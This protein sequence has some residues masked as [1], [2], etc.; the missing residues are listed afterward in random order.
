V[1]WLIREFLVG[2][3]IFY[4][5]VLVQLAPA[6]DSALEQLYEAA[7]RSLT[8]G[9]YPEAQRAFEQ[10][11]QAHPEIAEIRANLGL[12][13]FEE[14]QFDK[15]VPELRRALKLKPALT[16][17][18]ALLAMSLSELGQYEEALAG[19]EKGFRSPDPQMKRMCGLQ[20]ER[21]Y[22]GM[23]RDNKAVEIAL[24]MSHFYPDDPEVLYHNGR[25]FGNFAF[26]S[27]QRLSQL[28]PESVWTHQAAAEAYESQGS[29]GSAIS[30]YRQVLAMEPRRP[31]VHYRLGRTLLAQARATT[32]AEDLTSAVSEFDEEL[33]LDPLNA[34][35]AY[36]IGEI[37][38]RAAEF[39]DAQEHF[40]LALKIYPDLE[41]AHLGLAAVL[42]Y[43]RKPQLALPHLQKAASLNSENEVTWYRLSQVERALGNPEE[44]Q[45]AL[46]KFHELHQ[47]KT[48]QE[49]ASKPLFSAEE[50]TKQTLD[51][52]EAQ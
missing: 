50:V 43:L 27:I 47:R 39:E 35:A 42:T 19:L 24:E 38:R 48:V 11:A 22:T 15:A 32:S 8:A 3:T 26:L 18:A 28:A 52:N 2:L 37:H 33:K 25:I 1:N 21:A 6:Q 51:P 34:S 29:Y 4:M 44:A 20:L 40:E 16:K 36:E 17:S 9:N 12:I 30:E 41:E 31:G 10:L 49:Q 23:K 5:L 14:K 46:A 13:Y 45:R 7:Q